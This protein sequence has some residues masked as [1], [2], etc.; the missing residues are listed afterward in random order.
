MQSTQPKAHDTMHGKN[1]ERRTE[2][3]EIIQDRSGDWDFK[4]Q[5]EGAKSNGTNRKKKK[6]RRELERTTFSVLHGERRDEFCETNIQRTETLLCCQQEK[7]KKELESAPLG[8]LHLLLT[9]LIRDVFTI[10]HNC[11]YNSYITRQQQRGP[12][13]LHWPPDKGALISLPLHTIRHDHQQRTLRFI[14]LLVIAVFSTLYDFN[15]LFL[16]LPSHYFL[17]L[18]NEPLTKPSSLCMFRNYSC[19]FLQL[20][21]APYSCST[22]MRQP[23]AARHRK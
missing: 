14:R 15:T 7:E 9:K 19:G 20:N 6:V 5:R 12:E 10:W 11:G 18:S 1:E 3:G 22:L 23:Q 2:V 4:S 17:K 8:C 16:P 21:A 13:Q